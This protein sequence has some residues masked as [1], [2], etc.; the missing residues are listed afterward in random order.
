MVT[1]GACKG[2]SDIRKTEQ[3]EAVRIMGAED[4]FFGDYPDTQLTCSRELIRFIEDI[5]RKVQPNFGF[6]PYPEDTHQDHRALAQASMPSFHFCRYPSSPS[7][8][9]PLWSL[10]ITGMKGLPKSGEW[11][12]RIGEREISL[13]SISHF[14]YLYSRNI[15]PPSTNQGKQAIW[16]GQAKRFS[17]ITR[18]T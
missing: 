12:P 15:F 16:Q 14:F 9:A 11:G 10:S 6:V 8:L 1:N 7:S 5:A 17:L 3:L 4:I 13:Y 2:D 18:P